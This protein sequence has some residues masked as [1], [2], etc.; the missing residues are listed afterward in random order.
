M[1]IWWV[2][3]RLLEGVDFVVFLCVMYYVVDE[4]VL[5]FL[6]K[7]NVIISKLFGK[8]MKGLYGF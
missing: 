6:E 3:K 7:V 4:D 8:F 2:V 1:V 5:S